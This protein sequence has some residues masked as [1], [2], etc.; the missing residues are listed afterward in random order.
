MDRLWIE[1]A[2]ERRRFL[3]RVTLGF[4]PDHAQVSTDYEK[5]MRERNRLLKDGVLDPAWLDGLEAQMARAGMAM[6]RARAEALGRLANAQES[7]KTTSAEGDALF[8][9]ARL[10][11]IG[12]ME[13]RF[14]EA[15]AS[16]ADLDALEP[17]E[18]AGLAGAL[19]ASRARDAAAGR[20][21]EGPHRSD[22]DAVYAEKAMPARDCSTGEQKALLI[23]LCLADARALAEATGTAPVLLFDEVAA[24]LDERRRRAL[25]AEV[26][27]LGAQAWMTGTEAGLFDGLEGARRLAV[28]ERGGVSA[29]EVAT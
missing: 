5:A 28:T 12:N 17:R 24:H 13:C 23:S 2:A 16:G 22:L 1:G 25:F 26:D 8:P 20:T 29:I 18:A 27:A 11:I 21:L 10:S 14:S 7:G 6:A 15:L 4:D 19:A 9:R 3:D